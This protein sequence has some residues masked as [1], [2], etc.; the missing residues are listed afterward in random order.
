M[1]EEGRPAAVARGAGATARK[2]S[3]PLF[4]LPDDALGPQRTSAPVDG[5][6]V[7]GDEVGLARADGRTRTI[8]LAP[9]LH[10][11]QRRQ[12]RRRCR[13]APLIFRFCTR[14]TLTS[15]EFPRLR[16][17]G[18]MPRRLHPCFQHNP[19]WCQECGPSVGGAGFE[20]GKAAIGLGGSPEQSK[21]RTTPS[22]TTHTDFSSHRW[23]YPNRIKRNWWPSP[24]SIPIIIGRSPSTT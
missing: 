16:G 10:G 23:R 22:C 9:R 17:Q 15:C 3:E 14:M 20:V 2:R 6:V 11:G 5:V 18:Q 4:A 1:G 13:A 24:R 21:S 12:R 19:S 7:R 8:P